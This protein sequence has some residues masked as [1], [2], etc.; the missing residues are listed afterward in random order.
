MHLIEPDGT[1]INGTSET[2]YPNDLVF[3]PDERILYVAITRCETMFRKKNRARAAPR[4][5][6]PHH[7]E[8]AYGTYTLGKG[9]GLQ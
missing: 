3:S 7:V 2:D 5:D 9:A 1:L 4:Q 6:A 8:L